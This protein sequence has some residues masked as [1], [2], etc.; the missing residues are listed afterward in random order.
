[1]RAVQRRGPYHLAG[2]SFGG[3][4]AF[5]MANRLV[6]AGEHVARVIVFD[7][8][9]PLPASARARTR[10]VQ[11]LTAGLFR[12]SLRLPILEERVPRLRRLCTLSPLWRFFVAFHQTADD[13]PLGP[14]LAFA[15]GDRFDPRRIEGTSADVAWDYLVAL[16]NERPTPE[17][18]LLLIPGLDGAAARRA[19]RVSKKLE[20]LNVRYATR[21]VYPGTMDVFA[22]RD[23]PAV[24][25]WRAYASG[26]VVVHRFDIRKR[27]IGPHWDMMGDEN[28]QLFAPALRQLL[29][30][31]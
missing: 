17:D 18:Q 4:I 28:V 29:E 9:P 6:A 11:A 26:P 19:L 25:G 12:L 23:N 27:L 16:A 22:V 3:L 21:K 15:F 5:E 2:W 24:E 20:Q 7:S 1:M 14:L 30:P 10:A 8:S 13:A 31:P